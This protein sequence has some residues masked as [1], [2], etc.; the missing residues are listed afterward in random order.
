MADGIEGKVEQVENKVNE[1]VGETGQAIIDKI[2]QASEWLLEKLPHEG[3]HTPSTSA[4][5]EG[6]VPAPAAEPLRKTDS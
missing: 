3:H 1:T 2:G 6:A 4:A 5:T